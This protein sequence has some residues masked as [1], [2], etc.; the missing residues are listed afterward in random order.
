MTIKGKFYV[1]FVTGKIIN[2]QNHKL[3]IYTQ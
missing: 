2:I 3:R 1:I